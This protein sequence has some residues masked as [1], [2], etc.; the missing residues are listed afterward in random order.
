MS[1]KLI[2][3]IACTSFLF[4]CKK[5]E[6]E[7]NSSNSKNVTSL[8]ISNLTNVYNDF[9]PDSL[10]TTS[11]QSQ[12]GLRMQADENPCAG[13]DLFGCQP[14]LVKM[15]LQIGREMLGAVK[16]IATGAGTALGDLSDGASGEAVDG[17]STILYS[18]TS[19][20]VYSILIKENSNPI[21]YLDIND[22]SYNLK[23]DLANMPND[24]NGGGSSFQKVEVSL[25]YTDENTWDLNATIVG[26]TCDANDVRAPKNIKISI[27]KANSF[28]SGKAMI[29]NNRWALF[30]S[31]PTCDTAEADDISMNLYTDF[32]GNNLAT[33][34]K[35]YMMKNTATDFTTNSSAYDMSKLCDSYYTNFNTASANACVTAL[36]SQSIA[37]TSYTNPFCTTAPTNATWNSDC[38]GTDDNVAAAAYSSSSLWVSPEVFSAY[39]SSTITLPTAL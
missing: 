26:S 18:K 38:T 12:M 25:N 32:V 24:D 7:D 30:T 16:E 28:W 14:R 10:D 39:S 11:S 9:N 8:L 13:T 6:E 34:V 29:N 2:L 1:K 19:D 27:S 36:S 17:T 37:L 15:Y 5:K 23:L 21:L 3:I 22:T 4:S 31:E 33:K 35:V 20:L